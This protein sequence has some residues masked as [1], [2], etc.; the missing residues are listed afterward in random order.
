MDGGDRKDGHLIQLAEQVV[1]EV[2]R[3][4]V[5]G[6]QVID[7]KEQAGA[8]GGGLDQDAGQLLVDSAEAERA[9]GEL[10]SDAGQECPDERHRVEQMRGGACQRPPDLVWC[11]A[12]IGRERFFHRQEGFAPRPR[13]RTE[14]TVIP[15]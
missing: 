11:A 9:F 14:I 12:E 15:R 2:E 5:G 3:I 8:A 10:L 6:V 13:H 4:R 7:Q 1:Q